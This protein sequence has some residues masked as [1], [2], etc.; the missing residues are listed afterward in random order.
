MHPL[1]FTIGHLLL[2]LAALG[3]GLAALKGNDLEGSGMS[4]LM[5]IAL[6]LAALGEC[7]NASRPRPSSSGP[8]G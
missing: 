6:L 4:M 7:S 8:T 3:I 5:I 2:I 1:R